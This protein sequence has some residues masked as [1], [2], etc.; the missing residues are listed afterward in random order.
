MRCKKSKQLM[1]GVLATSMV[2]AN[3]GVIPA[4]RNV[5]ADTSKTYVTYEAEEGIVTGDITLGNSF[6]GA[7]GWLGN[8]AKAESN[9]TFANVNVASAG[10]YDLTISY[11][12]GTTR[13]FYV[14][15]NDGEGSE[16]VCAPKAENAWGAALSNITTVTTKVNLNEGS[17]TI[18]LYNEDGDCP[19][20]D[21]IEVAGARYQAERATVTGAN[22]SNGVVGWFGGAGSTDTLTVNVDAAGTYETQ[23]YYY[24]GAD[25]DFYVSVN[26]G[27]AV[28]VTC[29]NSGSWGADSTTY[30][31]QNFD[32]QAG[33]NTLKFFNESGDCPN[34]DCI[35]VA[36][37]AN[38]V[39]DDNTGNDTDNIEDALTYNGS[40]VSSIAGA[41]TDAATIRGE[42]AE[43]V[44]DEGV[45][46]N[47]LN[48]G[49][50][51]AQAGTLELPANLY[52]NV[53]D[54]FT[55]SM[56]VYIDANAADYTRL[57]ESS[58]CEMGS[59]GAPWNSAGISI[60]LGGSN[61]WRTEVFVGK[62]GAA[63]AAAETTTGA[64]IE[65]GV[66]RGAWHTVTMSVDSSKYTLTVDGNVLTEKAGDF[67]KLFGD[68]NYLASYVNNA[69]GD[70][71]YGDA[72]LKAKIDN[73]KFYNSADTLN[74]NTLQLSYDF[75]SVEKV[76]PTQ[77]LGGESVYTD[78]TELTFV[79]EI[80][81]PNGKI[82]AKLWM[83]EAGGRYFYSASND[84]ECVILAS[85]LGM[86][87]ESADFTTGADY[88]AGSMEEVTD[89][90]TLLNGKH[91]GE[92]TDVCNEYTFTLAK[93]GKELTVK[94]RVYD[95]G[96][97]Y[98]YAMNEGATIKNEASESVFADSASLWTYSQP[99]V[100]YEGT[101]GEIPMTSVFNA[102]ATY[103]TP[104]LVR[105]G[106][107]WVLLTEAS[108]FDDEYSYCSSLLKTVENSKNLKWAFGN[109][110]AA[111]VVMDGA[112]ETPWRVAVIGSDLNA[113]VNN[114]IVTSVCEDAYDV[115]YSF[116]KTGKLAWSWWSSTGDDPIAF[117][118][119]FDYIDFAAKNG[120]E[121]V[122][123]DYGWVLWDDY[124][125]KVKELVDYAE[126]KGVGIWLWYGVNNVGHTAAGA[127]P[128]Y[129]LLD[130]ATI[131]TELEWANEI[132]VK[133]VKVDYYESDN[134]N[135][136]EQM[137]LCAKI[138][139]DNKIMV[140]FHGC[141]NPGGENRTFPNVLSYEAVYGAEYYKWRMEPSTANIITYLFTRNAV[142]SAD[143]T[144]TALPV[145]GVVATHGFMLATSIYVESGLVHFAENV[146][147]YEGYMGLSL[148]NDMPTTW[149]ETI[150]AEGMPGEYGSVARRSGDDWYVAAITTGARTTDISLDFLEA[151]KTYT[152]YIYKTNAAGDDIEVLVKEVTREDVLALELSKDDGATVKLTTKAFDY[153]TDYNDNYTYLEAEDATANGRVSVSTNAFSAQY[154]SGKLAAE[155]IGNGVDNNVTYEITVSEAGVYEI[156]VYYISGNDRRFLI[157]VNGDDENRLRT[158]SLNS[159][160]WVTVDKETLYIELVEGKNIIKFYNDSAYA[161]NLDRISVSKA[162]VEKDVTV[163]DE[164]V[165]NADTNPGA[166]YE[167]D[168]YEAED[169]TI[170]NGAT[171]E[172]TLVGWI[173]G[174]SYVSF[175]EIE[176]DEAG[177]YYLRIAYMTGADRQ[178]AVSVNDGENVFVDCP[179]SG[180][181]YS[182][183]AFAYVVVE[184][185]AGVN[186]IKLSNPNGDAPNLDAIGISKTVVRDEDLS[187]GDTDG[188]G[189]DSGDENGSN[190][191]AGTD[192][193]NNLT[194][195]P[196]T[197]DVRD[198]L[199]LILI[200]ASSCI[201]VLTLKKRENE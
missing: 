95:D 131:K 52:A 170:A 122:C 175:D 24:T 45:A 22:V 12:T 135:T 155:N 1:A 191:G 201:A 125:A 4:G 36:T 55:I 162:T 21:Y 38:G 9:V 116:V 114:D 20:L 126:E 76:A 15:V 78:G 39:N 71:I 136:M 63:N 144:P 148:M 149:D 84:G 190:T 100:T 92:I 117:E 46:S 129:S 141:T 70:S 147:V 163:S 194:T 96:V 188:T 118:P 112:F 157:S 23:I 168:V 58:P 183:P 75:E 60:D 89:T 154:S 19:D 156:N 44:Y 49:G 172:N 145:A 196:N 178:F 56:D 53:T 34:F 91:D 164:T 153:I 143:F 68:S 5:L 179:S 14:S 197:G 42:K 107:S 62:D 174:N 48:L 150:V 50:G 189:S 182:N 106:D 6:A 98:A 119:Q 33:S 138:A 146:N 121:Y 35:K 18:V 104:S 187:S 181:Y 10:Q 200:G 180:D 110:Q 128:K 93:S 32:L 2:V 74:E 158:A 185:K 88:V 80:P 101:Y 111:T 54:G 176:V 133:G 94:L 79:K 90:Y 161:P 165:D 51:Y 198:V 67:S 86:N 85:Q 195:T 134:Q 102:A 31:T 40:S 47:V 25:R 140:L 82:V 97:A 8:K 124:K 99:N 59:C 115:D 139:A 192:T 64:T 61:L 186:T 7:V 16:V 199:V 152:A 132:G 43:V 81:S 166:A 159:G 77:S 137:Y 27:E 103:T 160:D 123:L 26:D 109:K 142:G 127:Y 108:V 41:M 167:Y 11:A 171:N 113:I 193:D 30:V 66:S 37:V 65:S 87:T 177:R 17:N 169:A 57:F 3:F 13:S 73:V 105:T 28:K 173:G 72:S 120:W 69:I 130:E 29:P 151:G 83:D 184:L